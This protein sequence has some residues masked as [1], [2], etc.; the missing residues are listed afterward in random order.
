MT[1]SSC[2]QARA[3]QTALNLRVTIWLV[4]AP[5]GTAAAVGKAGEIMAS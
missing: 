2:T 3:V 4:Q 5:D 1:Y